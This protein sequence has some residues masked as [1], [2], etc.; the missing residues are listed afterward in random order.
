MIHHLQQQVQQIFAIVDREYNR[1]EL[2]KQKITSA[3]SNSDGH[4]DG[5][6]AALETTYQGPGDLREEGRRHDNDFVGIADIRIA[7]TH[8]ELTTHL[9]PFLPANLYGSPHPYPPESMEKLLDIQFRLLREE[10][11]YV[12]SIQTS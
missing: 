4:N 1:H 10:L 5:I 2:G 11:M 7:P 6:L 3:T 8:D 12:H 9:P